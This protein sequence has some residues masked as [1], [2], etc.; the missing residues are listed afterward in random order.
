MDY[1]QSVAV[2][3]NGISFN[4]YKAIPY[5][6]KIEFVN[7]YVL[8]AVILEPDGFAYKNPFSDV[9]FNYLVLKYYTDIELNEEGDNRGW[10]HDFCISS[11]VYEAIEAI[12]SEDLDI[13]D[14]FGVNMID[15]MIESWKFKHSLT[16]TV[17]NLLSEDTIKQLAKSDTIQDE[18]RKMAENKS[19]KKD[20]KTISLPDFA[21]KKK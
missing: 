9:G 6:K 19:E 17:T 5:E 12:C 13:T 8:S 3:V 2:N 7:E 4:V 11:G 20:G 15:M 10:I 16:S 18:V 21:K 14:K 1:S